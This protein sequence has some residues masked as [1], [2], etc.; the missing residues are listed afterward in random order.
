M[1]NYYTV[2]KPEHGSQEWLRVRWKNK[3]GLARIS[4]SVAAAVHNEH[5]Y[6]SRADLCVE[7]LAE[8]APTPKEANMAMERGNR[9]E[10]TLLKW[11]A[12]LEGINVATP[13]KMYAF[14]TE[15]KAVRLIA[16]LD[17][18][19]EQGVPVE[20]KTTRKMW[21]GTLPRMWYWQGVQQAICTESDR[22]EWAI[23]DSSQELHRYTQ[24]VSSDEKAVH[25]NACRQFLQ[26]IDMGEIPDDII[27][28][29][30]HAEQ[31]NPDVKTKSVEL[32]NGSGILFQQ[33]ARIKEMIAA[34]EK[35]ESELKAQ[36]GM[37]LGDAEEGT[38]EDKKVV[39]WKSQK[40]E[41]FDTK[42]FES[43][44]PA[45]ASKFRKVTTF[46]VMRITY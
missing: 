42:R 10:P 36:V 26:A 39:S 32:P 12:D 4:A 11:F 29:L 35:E 22:V 38:L 30:K 7:L 1:D 46:R 3:D 34:L 45:L 20:V 13:S 14:E 18:I 16:T 15:D 8:E 25:L 41:T 27:I 5:N 2:D 40:R 21:D 43:E 37:Y 33:L 19:T 28:N 23:F 9:L 31:L 6:M 24:H 17:G 44:H